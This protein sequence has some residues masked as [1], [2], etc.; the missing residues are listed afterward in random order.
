[1]TLI[2][3]LVIIAYLAAVV[4]IG[5]YFARRQ[6]DTQDFFLG[7]GRMPWFAVALS[8]VASLASP[9]GYLGDPGE[10]I[11]H[12]IGYL[13]RLA[14]IPF[15][16]LLT[17]LWIVPLFR[18]ANVATSFQLLRNRFG[19]RTELLGV[20]VW[21]YMQFAFLGL[22]L[23]LASRLIGQ[24][25]GVPT[26]SIIVVIGIA[27]IFYTSAGGL[28]SVV[29]T[30]VFQFCL[31]ATGAVVTLGVVVAQTGLGPTAW[32]HEVAGKTHELPPLIS[33]DLSERHTL[34][35]DISFGLIVNLCYNASDQVIVQ[36]YFAT[37]RARTMMIANYAAG[38]AYSVLTIAVG[39]ALLTYYQANPVLLP[40]G[41]HAV[42]SPEFADKAFP[43]F[44]ANSFP[45]GLTGLIIAGLLGAAKS[46]LE[47][48]VN[49][50]AS[51]FSN[52][53]WLA[54][55]GGDAA[56]TELSRARWATRV[57]GVGI[58]TMA[59]IADNLPGSNNIIDIAQKF[60]HLGLGPMGALFMVAMSLQ[61]VK[62]TAAVL[63]LLLGLG[64]AIFFASSEYFIGY[65]V[66]SPLLIIPVCW[67]IT[68]VG[69][70]VLGVVIK[71]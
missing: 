29:W 54:R 26:F 51:V 56:K 14:A 16:I 42:T 55:E 7:G 22:V 67:L 66:I 45:A 2:D 43:Y 32:W 8:V 25:V 31:L 58:V 50:L 65:R 19:R 69:A 34:I 30:D 11:Q 48:G 9:V 64:S 61:Y 6:R 49:S 52:D 21:A 40:S 38:A 12:G 70:A 44:I 41:V 24:M 18:R 13:M 20:C 23:L 5:R 57:V 33:W 39:A 36:R 46:T 10:I 37:R 62:P 1:M 27:S 53:L 68:L 71:R 60:V 63:S 47:S 4:S 59:L 28:Q 15:A 17:V 3:W 35:G